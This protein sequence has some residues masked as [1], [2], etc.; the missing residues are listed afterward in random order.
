MKLHHSAEVW[1][2][3]HHTKVQPNYHHSST[4]TRTHTRML[5]RRTHASI[6]LHARARART[7]RTLCQ[8]VCFE[9]DGDRPARL[10][11]GW[12]LLAARL[13]M[14]IALQRR[15]LTNHIQA[16]CAVRFAFNTS[17]EIDFNFY[18]IDLNWGGWELMRSV[19]ARRR[20]MAQQ[21]QKAP[22][23]VAKNTV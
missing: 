17:F 18:H 4:H 1:L 6:I 11:L 15:S 19:C 9:H 7:P 16:A 2:K 10:I 23:T 8:C 20:T 13:M 22:R 12:L 21:C 3:N 14:M 5:I